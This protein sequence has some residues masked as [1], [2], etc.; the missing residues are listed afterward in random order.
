MTR[1]LAYTN[2]IS[3]APGGSIQV[4]VS[5]DGLDHY[6]ARLI[7]V[8][9]GDVNPSGPGYREEVVDLEFGGP[10]SGRFQPIHAGSYGIA[11]G[12]PPLNMGKSF[13]MQALIWPTLPGHGP[14]T[15]LS[16]ED[17]DSSAGFRLYL[18]TA[19][20]LAFQV[21]DSQGD[22]DSISTGSTLFAQRWYLASGEFDVK[23]R[24]LTVIQVPLVS[25][26]NV[27]DRAKDSKDVTIGTF[28]AK[29]DAVIMIAA[30]SGS[31]H[32]AVEHFNGRIEA[33]K[34]FARLLDD[35]EKV[36][37]G[38]AKS[39]DLIAAW[40]FSVDISTD[41]ISDV[42]DNQ[43][44]GRLVN[45]PARGVTGHLWNGDEH[46]W[47]KNFDHYA[48]IHFHDDDLYDCEWE[49]DIEVKLPDNLK[50][51]VYAVHLQSGS[52]EYYTPFA[53]R[54]PR[55]T[56]SA[57]V[58]FILPTASYM[59]YANNR[60]G[61]DVPETEIVTGRLVQ[62]NPIDL[63]M[64]THPEIG[65]SFYD[66]HNDGSGVYYSS[67]LRPI[68][69]MQPKQIGHLGG[70]GSNL[71]QF[72]ADTHI[73]GWLEQLEQPFDVI[74]DEDLENE[75]DQ[76]L[77]GYKAVITGTH[78]EY[79]SV[80]MLDSL[81][82]YLNAGGRLMY[83]GGNGFYWRVSFH[84]TL[85]GVIECRKSEDG[86][87]VYPPPPGEF[88]ASFT[89]EYTGLWRRN[90]RA[91]NELVGIG[92]VSQGFDCSSPFILTEASRD[93]RASFI[94]KGVEG[95]VVGDYGL[96]GGGAAGLELDAT[97]HAWG[98]PPN[99]LVLA[100]SER[101]SDLYLM[102]PE[103]MDD[104]APGLGGTE[105]EIIRAEM[106]FFETPK[107]GA[108]FSTGSIAWCGSLSHAN[109]SNDVARIT[110]NVLK[111]FLDPTPFPVM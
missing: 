100:T 36:N 97:N 15:I 88:Y 93:P 101:H 86:I 9:Q 22:S 89:G 98:T 24:T 91:P 21:T 92:M 23:S 83:L 10:F 56:R 4:K 28:E 16:Y 47:K 37:P 102:T 19:G 71:W 49:T 2:Q 64:Q 68:V 43:L 94:F 50:S 73:L 33:P 95:P 29:P 6:D 40:D 3:S 46:C 99:T 35:Y 106:V 53:V 81:Q 76:V 13:S 79:Y 38:T 44:D 27:H 82:S 87:R 31:V 69:Q 52:E 65:L 67:R 111:R 60:I 54:P 7:R 77:D 78:P 26:P 80:G 18:D 63:F 20:T 11:E 74:T 14:Q 108:V 103:D 45:L 61:I 107:G 32:P 84:P 109:Y 12:A 48:A 25:T 5:C 41:R 85:P 39:R 55:G 59:A 75:G 105:A 66:V 17:P 62:I 110:G 70:V 8:I 96:S 51:G 30:K 34:L 1:I 57:P 90:G 42:S 58:A 104:P 72:N